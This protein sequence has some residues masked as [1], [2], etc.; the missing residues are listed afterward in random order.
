MGEKGDRSHPKT[1]QVWDI[2]LYIYACESVARR[3]KQIAIPETS[4]RGD[5]LDVS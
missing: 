3:A 2:L 1:A 4:Y 5:A